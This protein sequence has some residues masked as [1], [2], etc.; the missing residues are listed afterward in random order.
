M[1]NVVQT[2]MS[3]DRESGGPAQVV[4]Q[5]ADALVDLG[6]A[7]S[8]VYVDS[9]RASDA[10]I[11]AKAITAPARA[12]RIGGRALWSTD[13]AQSIRRSLPA[14]GARL[15]H[16]NGLWGYTNFI[17]GNYASK[18]RIPLV[19]SPHGMLEPWALS[20]K[21]RKKRIASVLYQRR[22]LESAAMFVV[23]AESE[24][25]SVRRAGFKQPIA[26]V[27]AGVPLPETTAT[28]AAST[29]QRRM[30]FM[31]RIHPKKGL[32]QFVDAWRAVRQPGWKVIVAGP[33]EGGHQAEIQQLVSKRQ[34]EA[35]FD[36][37]GPVA[38]EQKRRLFESADVFVLP[39][40]S[41]NF[42]VV[43]AEALSY[44]IPVLT[45][46]GTPWAVLERINAGWWVE[47]DAAGIS[48][49]LRAAL[50]T[51]VEER[52]SMG[53]S[54]RSLITRDFGWPMAARKTYDAYAWLLREQPVR[55]LHV[56]LD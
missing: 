19:I 27:P 29:A 15:I 43:I 4:P 40:F 52:S 56:H 3:L 14:G 31:S 17:A 1:L 21:A 24:G 39:T 55:P 10:V 5:L 42:G 46:R 22:L 45:T 13:F 30:L 36:F 47:P 8:L 38:G 11:P 6:C 32:A 9:L 54:G 26:I 44:G 37:P 18:H 35:D 23:S 7:V 51:T 2:V 49:G 25:E 50:S 20:Y 12:L 41:E 53:R 28:H 48:Q 33:D 34:L 16:D